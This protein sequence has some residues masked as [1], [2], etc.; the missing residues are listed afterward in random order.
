M[1]FQVVMQLATTPM[2]I[3]TTID[4]DPRATLSTSQTTPAPRDGHG[5][6]TSMQ[7]SGSEGIRETKGQEHALGGKWI[8][9]VLALERLDLLII[10]LTHRLQYTT[11]FQDKFK[12]QLTRKFHEQR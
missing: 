2:C 7:S 8:I 4:S 5:Q 6:M 9:L 10:V 11:R 1:N 3:Y 12:V